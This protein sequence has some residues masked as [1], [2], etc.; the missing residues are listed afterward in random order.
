[1]PSVIIGKD[2]ETGQ[3]IRIDDIERRSGLYILGRMGRGK[4]TFIKKLIE[5]DMENGHGV[6]FLDPHGDAIEDL[7]KRIPAKRQNDVIIL[8]LLNQ[9]YSFGINLLACPDP[10]NMIERSRTFAQAIDIFKKLFAN[11]QTEELDILLNQYLRN[12]FFP[13]IANQDYT[14]AE[15]PLFLEEKQF[16]DRLLQNPSIRPEVVRFWHNTFDRMPSND[17]R[18]EIASTRRRLDHF[19]DF[20]EIRH[21]VG[22]SK[23]TIDFTDIMNTGK[24]LFVKLSKTLPGDAWRIIGTILISNL[25]HAVLLREQMPEE[26]RRHFCIFV[27]EFQN[28]AS[29]DDF[30]VLFTQARKYAIATTIAHQERYGQFADNKRIAG[31]TD[32]AVIKIFFQVTPHDAREQA[33]E[34][35]KEAT[36]TETRLEPEL[37]V[38]QD[39]F[40]DL[41]RRGHANPQI[42]A[43]S[44]KYLRGIYEQLDSVRM[45]ME[46][47]GLERM[48]LQGEANL[49]RDQVQ[50][51]LVDERQER[52][53][54]YNPSTRTF[55]IPSDYTA[56]ANT[57]AAIQRL[58]EAHMISENQAKDLKS[59]FEYYRET[60]LRIR[61]IDRFLSAIM[62]NHSLLIADQEQFAQFLIDIFKHLNIDKGIWPILDLYVRLEF[63]DPVIPRSIPACLVVKYFPQQSEAYKES[64]R[65]KSIAAS[66]LA[67]LRRIFGSIDQPILYEG[68]DLR[69]KAIESQ[70]KNPSETFP[71]IIIN[72]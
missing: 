5:Q 18:E 15:I 32:A 38:S 3:V 8:D 68:V 19:G 24:I 36:T 4:T 64:Q 6:F 21:I 69:T 14:I 47:L 17:Q 35:A 7:Q 57:E 33:V 11:P 63:G 71:K 13:L 9:T 66:N 61:T 44:N 27:D 53:G 49:L 12:S 26:K 34:F 55:L 20:D 56:I 60:R 51:S 70:E 48:V 16:R 22:Q 30:A 72:R 31:A 28:F 65:Q 23:T 25:V 50:L 43:F 59:L 39:P 45:K 41:L 1:M 54:V 58:I 37:V 40:W 42:T 29:S 10:D 2:A 52:Q 67:S 62:Q 46:S